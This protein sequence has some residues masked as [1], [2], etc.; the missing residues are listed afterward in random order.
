[1][2]PRSLSSKL[3][4]VNNFLTSMFFKFVSALLSLHFLQTFFLDVCNIEMDVRPAAG[5]YNFDIVPQSLS[6][7][8]HPYMSVWD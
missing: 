6:I 1:M 8:G 3:K 7:E 5:G 2:G 4:T